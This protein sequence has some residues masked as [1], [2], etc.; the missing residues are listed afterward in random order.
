MLNIYD[1]FFS[2]LLSPHECLAP[3]STDGEPHLLLSLLVLEE[4]PMPHHLH[5]LPLPS[6]FTSSLTNLCLLL[7][8]APVPLIAHNFDFW[9]WRTSPP[10]DFVL[11][12]WRTTQIIPL[13]LEDRVK[14][15]IINLYYN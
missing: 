15:P 12:F 11:Q 6:P 14:H 3:I 5:T 10:V 2:E 1:F 7:L 8:A 13:V 4:H 9:N